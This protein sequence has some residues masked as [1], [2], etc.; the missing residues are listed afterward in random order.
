MTSSSS[1]PLIDLKDSD[2]TVL[3]VLERALTEIG[4]VMVQGHSVP[5]HLVRTMRQQLETYFSRPLSEK[6]AD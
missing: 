5:E 4:F 3:P 6:L 2:D 1:I